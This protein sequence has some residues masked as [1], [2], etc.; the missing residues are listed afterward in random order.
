[1]KVIFVISDTHFGH[2]LMTTVLTDQGKRLRPWDTTD[3]M[4]EVLIAN[5]NSLVTPSDKVYHLGDVFFPRKGRM[6]LSR[7]N[8]DKVLIRGNHDG[9]PIKDY[10]MGFRDIRALHVLDGI[11]MTHVP[12]H[13]QTLS[14]WKGNVHG[15]LHEHIVTGSRGLP[16]GRYVSVCVEKIKYTPQEW[17][18]VRNELVA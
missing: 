7:L 6:L 14:R 11:I 15:H 2:Q 13:P 3:E 5:W 1:M 8:G 9:H 4:D 10:L 12:V 16:D 18:V 17:S